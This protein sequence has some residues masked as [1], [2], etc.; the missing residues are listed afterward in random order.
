MSVNQ[1]LAGAFEE[2]ASLLELTGANAFRVNAHTKV[3]RALEGMTSDIAAMAATPGQLEAVDGIGKSSA[4]KIREYLAD[5][6]IKDLEKLRA[7]VPDA[8]IAVLG[9][10]GLGPKTVRRLWTELDI[11]S[12]DDLKNG[13]ADGSVAG[14]PRMGAKT[15]ANLVDAIAFMESSGGRERLGTALHH[16]ESI[17]ERLREVPGVDQVQYAGSLRRGRETIG[18]IDILL[19]SSDPATASSTFRDMP[20]VTSVLVRGDTKSSVR[21][22]HGM[23]VDLRV[24]DKAAFGAALLYFT[25]SK[26]HNVVLRERA[27]S[28]GQRLNEYGLFPDDG[29]E[30]P[31]QDRGVQPV[32][33]STEAAI[34]SALEMP[35]IPPELREDRGE[36]S[37]VPPADLVEVDDIVS[38]LHAHTTASDG[39]LDI[40]ALAMAARK[41]GRKVLA[42]TD[43]S[44]SSAQANGL[45]EDRLR[46]HAEAIREANDRIKGITLLAGSEVD[47]HA[48]GS[49][50]YDDDI[51]AMLDMVVASPHA[52]LR[53]DPET[54]TK[55]LCAA[56][57]HPL[58]SIIGHPTGRLINERKG[59]EPDMPALF[60]AAIEGDTAL[61]VNSNPWRL[62][63]R[64]VHVRGAVEAGALISI[65]TDAHRAEHLRFLPLGVI[66]A[67]RGWLRKDGCINTWT[68]ARLTKWLK[69]NR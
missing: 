16:A 67:R 4:A 22:E 32:A 12:L 25:G 57:R 34:Y 58:V 66:T 13:L 39:L 21:T 6:R 61:E 43:H 26:E 3:A 38:E 52:S 46:R 17:A 44:K 19:S 47:I 64:D 29:E 60:A 41:A 40:E 33:A 48:D 18:D 9:V 45:D 69:T 62:D 50:D 51:L 42:I 63:L 11:E 30:G 31:P 49:L 2:M 15:V 1:E 24:V 59:L 5:G 54:A 28:R 68:P 53:Q 27:I 8:L 35:F 36:F 56:A 55:R 14:M 20:E 37:S 10:P 65:N 7:E 23:Q